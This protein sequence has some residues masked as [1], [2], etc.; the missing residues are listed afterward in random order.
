MKK[1]KEMKRREKERRVKRKKEMKRKVA[2]IKESVLPL[3]RRKDW[4]C[5]SEFL[6]SGHINWNYLCRRIEK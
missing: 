6:P 5:L 2:A 3:C 4:D 1:G